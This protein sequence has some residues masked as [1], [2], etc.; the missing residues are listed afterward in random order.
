MHH[1]FR[2]TPLSCDVMQGGHGTG[3]KWDMLNYVQHT[4][5]TTKL[6]FKIFEDGTENFVGKNLV[7]YTR[8]VKGK[9]DE[10]ADGSSEAKAA[11]SCRDVVGC[12]TGKASYY[13]D[14][15]GK[16][17]KPAFQGI[18]ENGWLLMDAAYFKKYASAK[19]VAG[20][21]SLSG[22]TVSIKGKSIL[23][24]DLG[25]T[26]TEYRMYLSAS[27]NDGS[28]DPDDTIGY[29]NSAF[30]SNELQHGTV[31]YNKNSVFR[32]GIKLAS[33]TPG[34][35]CENDGTNQVFAWG[36]DKQVHDMKI[37]G[38][39]GCNFQARLLTKMSAVVDIGTCLHAAQT[40][41]TH[42]ARQT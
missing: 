35:T 10:E 8:L 18:C 38:E 33:F 17:G 42:Q 32:N 31:K 24:I 26:F 30:L 13:I 27:K 41:D 11:A 19:V 21:G 20:T 2:T 9:C 7:V 34:N 29:T 5:L 28:K 3:F 4:P 25:Y 37:G 1:A 40:L 22:D 12:G 16:G 23:E 36:T 6:R 15:D 39:F 14:P